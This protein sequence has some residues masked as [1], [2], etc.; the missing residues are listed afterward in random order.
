MSVAF[1]PDGK[2]ALSGSKDKTMRLWDLE[3]G[4]EVHCFETHTYAVTGVAFSADGR[5]ALSASGDGTLHLWQLCAGRPPISDFRTQAGPKKV[6]PPQKEEP[7]ADKPKKVPPIEEDDPAP[8]KPKKQVP[9][10]EKEDPQPRKIPIAIDDD[11]DDLCRR[12]ILDLINKAELREADADFAKAIELYDELLAKIK[13]AGIKD[14]KLND[15]KN[16]ADKLKAAWKVTD[17]EH[18]A[19]RKFIYE[20]WPRLDTTEDL[21]RGVAQAR[22]AL[23][24]CCKAGDKLSPQKLLK[25]ALNHDVKLK[26][27]R[28]ELNPSISSDDAQEAQEIEAVL[29]DLAKLLEEGREALKQEVGPG[30]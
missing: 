22:D 11:E 23:Q 1:S 2:R 15:Y 24:A 16:H 10:Q 28:A 21:I 9:D 7:N 29:D 14:P 5:R 19:A 20:R 25:V 4:K 6:P 30:K 8:P 12:A 13:A 27:R 26:L 18:K 17:A 3:T